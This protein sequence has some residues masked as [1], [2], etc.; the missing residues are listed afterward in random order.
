MKSALNMCQLMDRIDK[1]KQVEEDRVQGKLK[2]K[3]FPEKANPREGGYHNNWPRRDFPNQTS[4]T[5]AQLVN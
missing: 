3:M 4:S 5:R 1:Y 2:A